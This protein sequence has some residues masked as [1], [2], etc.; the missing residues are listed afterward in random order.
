MIKSNSFRY[1][2]NEWSSCDKTHILVE[3]PETNLIVTIFVKFLE[4]YLNLFLSDIFIYLIKHFA[5]L[6][7]RQ[8]PTFIDIKT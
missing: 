3:L 2:I 6:S 8:E 1:F 7:Y 5:N 4:Y